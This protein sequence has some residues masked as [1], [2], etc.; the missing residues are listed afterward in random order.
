[1]KSYKTQYSY[2]GQTVEAVKRTRPITQENITDMV[3]DLNTCKDVQ[4]FID[5]Y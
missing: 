5:K 1:M 2:A 4:E 3:I